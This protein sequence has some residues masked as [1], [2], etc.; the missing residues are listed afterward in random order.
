MLDEQEE[1]YR[2]C[3]CCAN[4]FERAEQDGTFMSGHSSLLWRCMGCQKK[5]MLVAIPWHEWVANAG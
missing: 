1:I 4:S 3:R 5:R 2:K